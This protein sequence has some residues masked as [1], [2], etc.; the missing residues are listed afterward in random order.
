MLEGRMRKIVIDEME[1]PVICTFNVLEHIQQKYETISDY[2]QLVSGII[3]DGKDE[4]GKLE[5]KITPVNVA[6]M[7]DGITAMINEGIQIRNETK[8][9]KDNENPLIEQKD[10]ARILRDAGISLA[11]AA[12]IVMDELTECIAPKKAE[13]AQ[14]E[15]ITKKKSKSTLRG[16]FML[17]KLSSIIRKKK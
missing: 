17:E 10:A 8:G 11:D 2:N 6:A 1:Y 13:T 9:F 4:T 14:G 5:Y 16:F 15:K 3:P 7:L 12:G